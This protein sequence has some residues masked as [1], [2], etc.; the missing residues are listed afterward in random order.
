M[1]EDENIP[2]AWL[3][4][5]LRETDENPEQIYVD[6]IAKFPNTPDIAIAWIKFLESTNR[7]SDGILEIEKLSTEEL[8]SPSLI[9][10]HANL[11]YC[12]NRFDDAIASLE[13]IDSATLE[14]DTALAT[15]VTTNKS[16]Y[17][18]E[19]ALF[20]AELAIRASEEINGDLPIATIL[21]TKGQIKIVLFEDQAP[22]TVANFVSLAQSG[23]YDGTR[24]HRV[25]PKF[26]TQ[27]GDPNS[28]IGA[29]GQPGSGGPGY[30][31][32]DELDGDNLRKH[33]AGTLSMA[34]TAEPDT[35]GSQFFLTHVPTPHLDGRHT[36]FG[37]IV[38]G[39]EINREIEKDDTIVTIV[40]SNTRDHEYNPEKI[41]E[42]NESTSSES[43]TKLNS[44]RKPTL[45][46]NE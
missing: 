26:M 10:L 23:Y 8:L 6:F 33:F 44:G 2:L 13:S 4:F 24:F 19:T 20:S 22:N 12:N 36:V 17:E 18:T 39:L 35:G 14:A 43:N 45:N 3:D 27:G 7:F 21:T 42:A 29:I 9:E 28:R 41:G 30:T 40:I 11:L 34:K 38:E 15:R 31:I 25:I 37:R 16:L 32:K 46:S 1:P 5:K